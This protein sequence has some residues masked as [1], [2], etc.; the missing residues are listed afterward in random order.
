MTLEEEY[1]QSVV[2]GV[3]INVGQTDFPEEIK[4]KATSL[5]LKCGTGT[6]RSSLIAGIMERFE[7]NYALFEKNLDLSDL[8]DTYETYLVNKNREVRILD[9]AGEFE[10]RAE[11]INEKGELLIEL[12]DG[13]VRRVYAGEVS[14]RGLYGYV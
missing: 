9:P 14:V 3:G 13:S 5:A 2:I 10:G 1:I 12:P 11:G 7:K 4:D 6:A 8:K